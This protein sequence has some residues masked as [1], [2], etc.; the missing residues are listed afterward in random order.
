MIIPNIDLVFKK[1]KAQKN[2]AVQLIDPTDYL[3]KR[4][5][6]RYSAKYNIKVELHENPSFLMS[7]EQLEKDLQKKKSGYLMANFYQSQRKR[8]DL[9]IDSGQPVGG[10]WSFDEE[11]RKKLPKNIELPRVKTASFN[12]ICLRTQ[13]NILLQILIKT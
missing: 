2:S 8:L 6:N 9:L 3:L 5:V 12:R 7:V 4:R 13:R 1:L 10:Q 11:N